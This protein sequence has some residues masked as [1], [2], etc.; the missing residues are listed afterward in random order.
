MGDNRSP[1]ADCKAT[2]AIN[3][4]CQS[5]SPCLQSDRGKSNKVLHGQLEAEF[6]VMR[7]KIMK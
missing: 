3:T 5:F 4:F 2:K 1:G 7:M 6:L